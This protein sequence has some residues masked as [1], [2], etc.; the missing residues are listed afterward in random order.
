VGLGNQRCCAKAG[1]FLVRFPYC[2]LR[3]LSITQLFLFRKTKFRK[4]KQPIRKGNHL[5]GRSY[6]ADAVC[7]R[8]EV[9]LDAGPDWRHADD[10]AHLAREHVVRVADDGHAVQAPVAGGLLDRLPLL[11]ENTRICLLLKYSKLSLFLSSKLLASLL[12]C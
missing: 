5:C 4:Y 12:R 1:F 10:Q 11:C 6:R 9:A 2:R 7:V 8:V 3:K